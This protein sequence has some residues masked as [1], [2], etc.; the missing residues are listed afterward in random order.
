CCICKIFHLYIA[1]VPL[2]FSLDNPGSTMDSIGAVSAEFSLDVFKEL[3]VHKANE[4]IVCSPLTIISALS[5]VSLGA[6]ENT[7]AQ[8]EKVFH[9]DQISGSGDT[10]ESQCGTSVSA[11]TALRDIFAQITRPSGNYSVDFA[12]RL[13]AEESYPIQPE[14][15]QCVKELYKGGLEAIN[16]QADADQAREAINSWVEGQTNG[17][18]RNILHQG[19]VDPQTQMVLVNAIS[20]K[21]MWQKAFKDEDTQPAAFRISEQERKPVQMMYQVGSFRVAEVA[22][23]KVRILEL[24]YASGMLCMLVI[25]PDD[26][27]GLEQIESSLTLQK[28]VDWTSSSAMQERKM[29]VYLPRM[30]IQEKYN[31]TSV[32]MALGITD[33]FSSSANLSGISSAEDL[34]LSEAVHEAVIEIDEAGNEVVSSAEAG[35]EIP[36]DLDEFRADHPFFFAIKHKPSDS[37][38]FVGRCVSP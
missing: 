16:F 18:I 33:L 2:L 4:N 8:I 13:Y 23:E 34:K 10:T 25:L 30:R 11:Q 38:L 3:K 37:F 21:G 5:L 1:I 27:S 12:S 26:V 15:L 14:Y 17:M 29:K 28:L 20:F 36:S 35:S 24:Q 31:L 7:R 6:K 22:S 19:S 9:F 32:L